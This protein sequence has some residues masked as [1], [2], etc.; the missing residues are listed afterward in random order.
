MPGSTDP[1]TD[2]F[3]ARATAHP[4]RR[5]LLWIPAAVLGSVAVT[6]MTAAL[7][8]LRP[9]ANASQDDAASD[10]LAVGRV[11]ELGG[12]QP[13]RRAVTVERG[14]GWSLVRREQIVFVLPQGGGRVVSAVCP[15]EG[16]EVEWEEGSGAF[17]CP[18]HDSRFDA[19]GAPT[20]GPAER[21]LA[22]LPARV[23]GDLLEVKLEPARGG[24]DAPPVRG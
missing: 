23:N 17:L 1:S 19:D 24:V 16:C 7:K 21:G 20:G 3:A 15:H 22:R 10:W 4:R 5:F 8:F 2:P 11:S 14:A 18:C 13:V 12:G 6:L 9:Q